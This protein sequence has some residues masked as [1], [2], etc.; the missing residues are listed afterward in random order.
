MTNY[1]KSEPQK[2]RKER[3]ERETKRKMKKD[4]FVRIL[5]AIACSFPL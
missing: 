3:K 2:K 5:I 1:I 4:L